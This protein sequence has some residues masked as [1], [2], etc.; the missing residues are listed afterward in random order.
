MDDQFSDICYAKFL[1]TAPELSN[2]ILAF[3]D[4]TD[5]L[6]DPEDLHVGMFVLQGGED[7]YFVPVVSKGNGVY[8]IDSIFFNSKGKFFPLTK[9]TIEN[10][11]STQKSSL[12][13]P[14][15]IPNSV[16]VNPSV[17][18]VINPP[19][20]G[21]FVYASTSRLTEFLGV[22]PKALKE[23]VMEKFA[24][25]VEVY[26][27]LHSMF[28]LEEL[29]GALKK[30]A[31]AIGEGPA[32]RDIGVRIITGGDNLPSPQVN[33]ILS[34]G[35]AID[36]KHPTTRLSVMS[37]YWTD[38]RYTNLSMLD[39]GRD[40]EIV[41]KDGSTRKGFAPVKKL[42]DGF[43]TVGKVG[44]DKSEPQFILFDNGDYAIGQGAVVVGNPIEGHGTLSA[45][46]DVRPPMMMKDIEIGDTF[47][48][49]DQNLG[50]IGVYEA[51]KVT[52]TF[53]GCQIKAYDRQNSENTVITGIRGYNKTPTTTGSEIFVPMA[54]LVIIL[55]ENVTFDL[56]KGV[57]AASNRREAIEWALMN[58]M[59]NLTF[60]DVEFH[61]NGHPMGKEAEVMESLVVKE[62]ID[63]DIAQT[64]IKKAKEDKRVTIYLSKKA[65]FGP[66]EIPQ[67]G[68]QPPAQVNP[69]GTQDNKLPMN[70]LRQAVN[71]GDNQTVESVVISELLQSQDL[72][73]Y[74]DEYLPDIEE[75]IDRLGRILFLGRIHIN[76]LGEGTDPDEVFALLSQLK[77]VYKM[78]GD[79]YGKLA[80]LQGNAPRK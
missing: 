20:T 29:F 51:R 38:G 72:Q 3:K 45:L 27:K 14:K 74:I 55:G 15:K 24:S 43:H 10:L 54:S 68:N 73:E 49:M 66:G 62:G 2:L 25:D 11:I 1:Q 52:M 34:M 37:Q 42:V 48:I 32:A 80:Q 44:N 5:E 40:Y 9:S 64:F 33:S 56:E 60:D 4:V 22:M 36:G 77:N 46:F 12:G 47:A 28:G 31:Q 16:Q 69:W 78:L 17:Y 70:S 53:E 7:F 59:I 76:K 58:S 8:P 63:P 23:Y 6:S 75:A 41:F 21:K 61:M 35:Y 67:F 50:Y 79:N 26:N 39:S 65:D 71:T 19:R 57:Q 18:D 30:E 13:K